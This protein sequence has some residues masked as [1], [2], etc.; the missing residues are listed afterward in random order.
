FIEISSGR[1][2]TLLTAPASSPCARRSPRRHLYRLP[3][4]RSSPFSLRVSFFEEYISALQEGLQS[5]IVSTYLLRL[6][7][8]C[9][10]LSLTQSYYNIRLRRGGGRAGVTGKRPVSALSPGQYFPGALSG[11]RP[12][13]L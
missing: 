7:R 12:L 6:C 10:S 11:A 5:T 13:S 3:I 9:P 8:L 4:S 2:T 1:E